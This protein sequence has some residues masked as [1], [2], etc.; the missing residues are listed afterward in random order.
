MNVERQTIFT[1]GRMAEHFGLG[2]LPDYVDEIAD[3]AGL[4]AE[5][6]AQ[7]QDVAH[8]ETKSFSSVHEFRLF[9]ILI[10]SLI[11][12][13]RPSTIIETGVLHGMTSAFILRAIEKNGAGRLISI[14]LPSNFDEG[15]A[16][17]DGYFATLPPEKAPGWIIPERYLG[18]W[19][20]VLGASAEALPPTLEKNPA[21][22]V[23]LHD[24]EHSYETMWFELATAWSHLTAKGILIC[25]NIDNNTSFFD[26]CRSVDRIPFVCTSPIAGVQDKIRFGIIGRNQR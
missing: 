23:F 11:R 15:P 1:L 5:L 8:F 20:L 6:E 10:Y 17:K 12:A 18:N 2:Y 22:D 16:N 26:F 3:R 13:L 14:D 25:D 24:S 19:E 9:R 7:V 21:I 4:I